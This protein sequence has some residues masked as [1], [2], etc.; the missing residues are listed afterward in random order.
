V[1]IGFQHPRRRRGAQARRSAGIQ[2]RYYNII[3]EA[4]DE[5][6]AALSGMLR[7]SARKP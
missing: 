2:V 7:R 6:K 5:M 1:I 3:Y 4:V